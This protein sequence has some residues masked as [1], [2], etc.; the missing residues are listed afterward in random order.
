MERQRPRFDSL[1]L[2]AADP[3]ASAWGLWGDDDELG[4]LNL[5]TPNTVQQAAAQVLTGEVVPLNL[6]LDAFIKPMNPV[7]KPCSH[8]II[9]KGHANDDELDINTQGSSHWDGLRH[10]PYQDS[11]QYYNGVTQ[12]SISGETKN[13]RLGV[14]N[15]ATKT[16]TGRGV[17]LDWYGWAQQ[18]NITIDHFSAHAIPHEQLLA[19]AEQ[20]KVSFE[21][22]DI[23]LIRT[24]W[25]A[26]YRNLTIEQR[27]DLPSRNVR[28]SCGIEASEDSIRWHWDKAFAAVASDTVAYEAWPSPKTWGVSMH[29]VFLSGWAQYLTLGKQFALS[30]SKQVGSKPI[31]RPCDPG[32]RDPGQ[33]QQPKNMKR[34]AHDEVAIRFHS[35]IACFVLRG[36]DASFE[37][38]GIREADR[39][40]D[41]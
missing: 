14:Q 28:S 36:V 3:K 38:V 4:T 9:A 21:V 25:L 15:L 17:L 1:P 35:I 5:L 40:V 37:D 2:H 34:F 6:P 23:L 20:Q 22:G 16:I 11:L 19:V 24:G 33:E 30:A 41:F 18:N 27:A 7:R 10:Y 39:R 13:D 26:A 12:A 29:E 32:R 8:H 31:Y